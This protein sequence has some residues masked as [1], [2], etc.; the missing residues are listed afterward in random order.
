[1]ARRE[2]GGE[3]EYDP[4]VTGGAGWRECGLPHELRSVGGIYMLRLGK[5]ERTSTSAHNVLTEKLYAAAGPK[6]AWHM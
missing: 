3:I 1:M 4:A 5:A 6:V 2:H